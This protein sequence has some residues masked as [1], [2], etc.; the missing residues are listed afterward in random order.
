M[1]LDLATSVA[2]VNI[3]IAKHPLLPATEIVPSS[4]GIRVHLHNGFTDFEA[5]REALNIPES[6]ITFRVGELNATLHVDTTFSGVPLTL[7]A[8]S[9]P[10]ADQRTPLKAVA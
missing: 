1:L 6:S 9:S 7:T 10:I 4:R 2:A 5:W 8:Y 3:L